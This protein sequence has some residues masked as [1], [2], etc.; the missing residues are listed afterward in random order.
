MT[1][2]RAMRAILSI[3]A[4]AGEIPR[5]VLPPSQAP[6]SRRPRP[7]R[8]RRR[9]ES[10]SDQELLR[11]FVRGRGV[12]VQVDAVAGVGLDVG[13]ECAGGRER[14]GD[15]AGDRCSCRST[16]RQAV[17]AAEDEVLIYEDELVEKKFPP[18][19]RKMFRDSPP[20][21]TWTGPLN[22]G[23]VEGEPPRVRTSPVVK[24]CLVVSEN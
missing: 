5:G 11:D 6:S 4:P 13:F 22:S 1:T 19:P 8:W 21:R 2:K 23:A 10:V 9:S 18:L 20:T 15:S 16:G 7:S 14:P 3:P 17:A 12:V 24:G